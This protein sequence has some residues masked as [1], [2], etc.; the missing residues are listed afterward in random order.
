MQGGCASPFLEQASIAAPAPTCTTSCCAADAEDGGEWV[1]HTGYPGHKVFQ[2]PACKYHQYTRSEVL[3][4]FQGG[5]VDIVVVG[6]SFVRQLFVRLV[7]L[8]RGQVRSSLS[9]FGV[10]GFGSS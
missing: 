8:L 9:G 2:P 7:H 10:L 5:G 6:D 3:D 1:D 4:Y